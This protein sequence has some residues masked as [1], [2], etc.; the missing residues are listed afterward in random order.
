MEKLKQLILVVG[1]LFSTSVFADINTDCN[2]NQ[3]CY[4]SD[5]FDYESGTSLIN[6][7]GQSGTTNLNSNDDSWSASVNLGFTFDRWNYSWTQARMSTNGCVNFV[8]R[9]DGK[10]SSNCSDYTPHKLPYR[11]YTLYPLWTDL[12]RGNNSKMLYK[13][14][15]DYVVFGLYYLK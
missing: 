15:D 11:N 9:S 7:Y 8:G 13:A 6:L 5:I 10:N 4:N 3:N 1:L 12:I 2:N 14:F